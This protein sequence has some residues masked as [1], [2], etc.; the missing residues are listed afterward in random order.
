MLINYI[1]MAW[2]NLLKNKVY[3]LINI[4]GLSIGLAVCMLIVLYVGHESS[5]DRFHTNAE[6]I[7]WIQGKIKMGTD[8]VFIGSM[9]FPTGPL[10]KQQEP[11]VESF[12][13]T[14]QQ[15]E[16]TIIQN[17]ESPSLKFTENKFHFADSNFFNFFSF[18]L[19]AGDPDEV[20]LKPFSVVI[21]EKAA[22]KYFGNENA[23]GKIIRYNNEHNFIVTGVSEKAPSNS[24]VDYD[25][26]ASIS[27]LASIP[28]E[29]SLTQSQLLENGNFKTYF[30]LKH[31]GAAAGLESRLSNMH[32]AAA[33]DAEGPSISFLATPLLSTH[34]K[35]N[36]GDFSNIRYIKIFPLVAILV[37]LL[38]LINYINL[39]TSRATTRAKEIGVRKVM[40]ADRTTIAIQFFTESALYTSIAFLLAFIFCTTFQPAFFNFLEIDLDASF[41]YS[42]AMLSAY[43]LLFFATVLLSASYPA[44]LLS[45]YKPF[46]VLYGKFSKNN[47]GLAIRKFLTV[48]QFT[49]S[50][51]LVISGFAINRQINFLKNAETGINRDNIVM[52][53]FSQAIGKHYPAFKTDVQSIAAV[54]EIATS[55]IALYKGHDMMGVNPKNSDKMIFLP[56]LSVDENFI[57]LLNLKWKAPPAAGL[58]SN[59]KDV[60]ILNET[61]VERLNLGNNPVNAKIDDQFTVAGILKDFNYSSL[62]NEI[63]ALGLIVLPA[64]D[65]A[66][67]FAKTG[68]CMFVKLN[69]GNNV[70]ASILSIKTAYEKFEQGKPF[71]FSF[72]DDSFNALYKAENRLSKILT[73]FTVFTML[74]AC[75]GLFGLS[76]FMALQ[77]TREI[78]IRKVL[79]ASV[80]QVILLLSKDF[81][82]LVMIAVLI[83]SPLAWWAVNKWLNNFAYKM[84]VSWTIFLSAAVLA[85]LI[86]LITLSF[87]AIKSATANPV[88]SLRSE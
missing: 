43:T 84:P 49:I 33:G 75:M 42:P 72:L 34:T 23:V 36:Y 18:K 30:T 80:G 4:T 10:V 47:N 77:R 73:I 15:T 62:H 64:N 14:K 31:P 70:H 74:I 82:Q 50:I 81:I 39:S 59:K 26:I 37:L 71:E 55:Q 28:E 25:F 9:S 58:L 61:A 38:A 86:A 57:S 52:I 83:A 65:T 13:R 32:K 1:K 41:L 53:P 11:N 45:A 29:R 60:M 3:S 21:S 67:R 54:K 44:L 63:A 76:T 12:L 85:L 2:R 66:S 40:G 20:L 16:N 17:P 7:F 87:R 22:K 27:S 6:K 24:S 78:G 88:N 35:A 68:G 79:G 56:V 8:S 51:I 46:L 69:A 5:F 19:A 48:M